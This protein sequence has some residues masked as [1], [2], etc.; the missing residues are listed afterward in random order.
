[1][2]NE[3]TLETKKYL[4]QVCNGN[5]CHVRKSKRIANAICRKLEIPEGQQCSTNG[6]YTVE[7]T[8][9]MEICGPGPM[10]RINGQTY[11]HMSVEKAIELIE[12]LT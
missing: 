3:S 11:E 7:L 8:P 6:K 2:E 4:I 12:N 5:T 1:M 10:M 9:C